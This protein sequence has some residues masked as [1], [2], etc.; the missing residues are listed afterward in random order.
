MK[1]KKKEKNLNLGKLR[2][3]KLKNLNQIQGGKDTDRT[4]EEYTT[5][6][7]TEG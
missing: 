5:T 3:T 6:F 1:S 7:T 4:K 2:I